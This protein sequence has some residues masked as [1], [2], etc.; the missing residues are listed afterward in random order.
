MT[1][2][3][4]AVADSKGKALAAYNYGEE[5][6]EGFEGTSA[7]DLSIPFISILQPLSPQVLDNNPVGSLAG[8]FYNTVTHELTDPKKGFNFLPC[9]KEVAYVEWI[10][11]LQGGGFVGIHETN[12]DV[13]KAAIAANDG[14]KFGKLSTGTNDL[15][16]T[17]YMYGLILDDDGITPESFA[18]LSFTSTK[19]KPFRDW[20]TS[21]YT[22]KGRPPMH[23]NRATLRTVSETRPGGTS[24]NFV[25]SPLKA[26][27]VES[28]IDPK[29]NK[30]LLQE[31]RDFREMVLSGMARAAFDTE[32]STGGDA[33]GGDEDNAPF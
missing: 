31:A 5:S 30:D 28:L 7:S 29:K 18:V 2:K 26:T 12:S 6:G 17:F 27:W 20:I 9:H 1:D 16:E 21:M 8:M 32:Q 23:A 13:V 15:I 22:L 11:R 4:I 25:V 3:Q 33:S 10:P 19:I 24:F 14:K